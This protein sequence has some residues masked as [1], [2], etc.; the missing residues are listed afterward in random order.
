M[1]NESIF[2]NFVIAQYGT[3]TDAHSAAPDIRQV[4]VLCGAEDAQGSAFALAY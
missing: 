3:V 2:Y 4:D 1:N